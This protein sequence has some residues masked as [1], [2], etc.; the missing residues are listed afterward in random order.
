MIKVFVLSFFKMPL[1]ACY[2]VYDLCLYFYLKMYKDFFGWGIHLITGRF[3]AGKSNVMCKIAYKICKR[4][5]NMSVLTNLKLDNF[6]EHTK[7]LPLNDAKDIVNAPRDCIVLIDEIG[8]IFNSRDFSSGQRAVPKVLFQHLCQCRK[9]NMIIYGTVQRYNLLDKQI[10]DISADVTVCHSHFKHPF[11]RIVSTYTYDIDDYDLY[12]SNRAFKPRIMKS[13]V[14]IQK[15]LYR[16]LYNTSEL[17]DNMLNKDYLS[18]DEILKNRGENPVSVT[19]LSK[20]DNRQIIFNKK[21]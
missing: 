15:S 16:N 11:T 14:Y 1:M 2:L 7:I 21:V 13:S 4:Y 3:G 8:T 18:D 10:R 9:R 12:S 5:K 20:K 6:P 19:P 17:I